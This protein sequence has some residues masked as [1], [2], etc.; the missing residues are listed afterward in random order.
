MNA[1]KGAL[2]RL[3]VLLVFCTGCFPGTSW[4]ISSSPQD[5]LRVLRRGGVLS[6]NGLVEADL[7]LRFDLR[8]G[9]GA[10]ASPPWLPV[11][12]V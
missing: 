3:F 12:R 8:H 5:A 7:G 10:L 4:F 2:A 9:G 1:G 11:S 6:P